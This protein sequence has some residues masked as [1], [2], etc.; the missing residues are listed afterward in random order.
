MPSST[1][2]HLVA[3]EEA[4]SKQHHGCIRRSRKGSKDNISS[5]SI[6]WVEWFYL[7]G[8]EGILSIDFRVLTR[9]VGFSPTFPKRGCNFV[10]AT[11][12]R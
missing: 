7:V 9:E 6:S 1:N 5:G 4:D 2:M 10:S 11:I 12:D 3:P 8:G